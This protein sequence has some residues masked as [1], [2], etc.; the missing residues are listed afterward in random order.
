MPIIVPALSPA[1]AQVTLAETEQATALRVGP[2]RRYAQS[3]T[4]TSTTTNAFFDELKSEQ[5]TTGLDG[6]FILRRGQLS[7]GTTVAVAAGDRQRIAGTPD[8]LTGGVPPNAA[9]TVAPVANEYLEFHHLD[10][11]QELRPAVLAGLKRC[12]FEDR[13]TVTLGS[14]AAE[15]D[16]TSSVYWITSP[17]QV[18]RYQFTATGA[19]MLPSAFPWAAPFQQAGHVW[20]AGWPDEYPNNLLITALRPHFTWVNGADSAT[21]PS[22]DTDILMVELNYVVA[23]AHI[24]AWRLF[25][26]RLRAAAEA[27]YQASQQE[28]ATEFTRMAAVSI[29]TRARAWSLNAPFGPEPLGTVAL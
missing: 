15:R 1:P 14:A 28:A 23:A 27:G 29:R 16:V 3:S 6:M 13:A 8:P 17:G 26:S 21:G 24:E 9:W 19:T 12:F 20:L 11:A 4:T 22:V 10:P 7:D 18:R 25:P 5:A 2:Y